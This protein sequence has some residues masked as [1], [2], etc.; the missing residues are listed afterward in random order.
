MGK[1]SKK[2]RTNTKPKHHAAGAGGSRRSAGSVASDMHSQSQATASVDGFGNKHAAMHMSKPTTKAPPVSVMVP[3]P[4]PENKTL[5]SLLG[6]D[7]TKGATDDDDIQQTPSSTAESTPEPSPTKANTTTDKK[8]AAAAAAAA[9][10]VTAT[11]ANKEELAAAAASST[12]PA[13]LSIDTSSTN[14]PRNADLPPFTM[15]AVENDKDTKQHPITPDE[16]MRSTVSLRE[17]F[18]TTQDADLSID[19]DKAVLDVTVDDVALNPILPSVKGKNDSDGGSSNN[20][21]LNLNAPSLEESNDV[22][23]GG[24]CCIIQ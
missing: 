13:P 11:K 1:K 15:D 22:Q 3:S 2:G 20:K 17:Q 24:D 23:Q 4:M 6:D 8:E 21:N 9:A 18:D 19:N 5:P 10:V 7:N 14:S 16:V 12:T